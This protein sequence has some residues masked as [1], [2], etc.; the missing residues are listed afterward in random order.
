ME[1]VSNGEHGGVI[2][3][4]N[5]IIASGREPYGSFPEK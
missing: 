1:N 2:R 3:D 5:Q 4:A